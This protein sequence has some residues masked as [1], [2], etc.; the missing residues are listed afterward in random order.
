VCDRKVLSRIFGPKREEIKIGWGQ[1]NVSRSF[2][3][4][5]YTEQYEDD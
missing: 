4:F 1:L 5:Y 2:K 3:I